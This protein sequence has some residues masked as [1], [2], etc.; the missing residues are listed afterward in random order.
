[1]SVYQELCGGG[2]GTTPNTGLK[3]LNCTE[4]K[5][6]IPV[7]SLNG[8][9]FNSIADFKNVDSWKAAKKAKN[10]VPLYAA[11]ELADASTEDTKFETGNF[12]KVTEKGVEKIVYENY[13][14]LKA[15][16]ILKAYASNSSYR[17]M[18]EFNEGG[19]YL[20]VF[21]PDGKKVRG[22]KIKSF[23]VT[24][25]RATKEKIPYV[26]VEITFDDKDDVRDAVVVKSDLEKEDLEG[27]YDVDGKLASASATNIVIE[28]KFTG[29]NHDASNIEL[30]EWN[31]TGGTITAAAYADGQ[32][33][34]TGTGL[35]SGTLSTDV[36]EK[37]NM[38]LEFTDLEIAI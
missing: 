26:K 35:V 1:M 9:E 20:G 37:P 25:T 14:S 17:Y 13:V 5:L 2:E 33:T 24:R 7:L 34:L 38:M 21:S 23:I 31:Y 6:D 16:D 36:L 3:N 28:A 19:D 18:F 32:Y 4:T 15:Y 22:R 30:D 12:S 11:Y 8:F 27:I 29:S 10:I